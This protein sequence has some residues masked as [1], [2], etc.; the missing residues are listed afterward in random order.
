MA[1]II[2]KLHDQ[3]I[4]PDCPSWLPDNAPYLTIT[5]SMAYGVAD[6]SDKNNLS[7]YDIYGFA[8]PPKSMVF[9]HLAGHIEGFG[10]CPT[11]FEQWQK[12]HVIDPNALAGKGK[13]W[14]F[15]IFSIVKFFELC[16]QNN[17]NMLDC[18]FTPENC[19]IHCTQIG[20]MVRDNRKM[21]LSKLVWKKMRS[22]AWSQLKKEKTTSESEKVKNVVDFEIMSNI[23]RSTTFLEVENEMKRRK[24]IQDQ[25]ISSLDQP[26]SSLD[27]VS[28][29]MLTKYYELYQ[30]GMSE[31][32]RFETRKING[33]DNKFLYHLIRLFDEAE[34]ILLEGTMDL[35]RA[36]EVMKAVRRGD[37]SSAEV[38]QWAMEK[39][40]SL[41][42]AYTNCKLPESPPIEP[43][44][45]LLLQCL[46]QHYGTLDK[47]I[48][49][50]DW[51][52]I[53]LKEIDTSL[54][55]IRKQLYSC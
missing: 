49:N 28:T 32:T 25:P 50:T 20:R 13:E 23:P 34:Q 22:Y 47:C 2:Q 12:A 16:R 42:I 40:K 53:T 48:A 4:I 10:N 7:D 1:N 35:Q 41:E 9:S 43:L 55:K 54:E 19:V 45:Q 38:N 29:P 51:A 3:G 21:F 6:T 11:K 5:G 14:D 26:I 37:W 39:E 30:N 33:Q 31:S 17:P 36:K 27:H 52:A 18:L 15:S 46:E 24:L 8:I 44:K